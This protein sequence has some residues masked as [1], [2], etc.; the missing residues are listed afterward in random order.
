MTHFRRY[1][2]E[3]RFAL[4]LFAVLVVITV[5]LT[6]S[7]FSPANFGTTLGLMT[8]LILAA[9]AVTPVF[10]AGREGIDLSVGP[11]IGFVSVIMV[12][13]LILD[14]GLTSPL[15][16]IPAGLLVGILI[17]ATNGVLA[18]YLRVQPIVA[19]L[20]TYLI[21]T[22]LATW[23]LPAPKG[24]VPEWMSQ[25]SESYSILPLIA[26]ALIWLL[27]KR[28]PLYS[29][30]LTIGGEDRAAYAAGVNVD[31]IRFLAYVIGGLFAAFAAISLTGLLGSADAQVGPN[32]TLLAIAAVALGGV[33]LAG[34]K[35]TMLGAAIGSIDIFLLQNLITH[36]NVSSFV[37]QIVYGSILV[38]A[39]SLNSD[40]LT[41]RLRLGSEKRHA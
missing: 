38:I 32:Y 5:I 10:L 22:G 30:I 8:P 28:L 40:V 26:V 34:G 41:R 1:F 7:R 35:G 13:V 4:L 23:I 14:L 15:I 24:P 18:V 31:F 39:V 27:I 33:S 16:V 37:L 2:S 12:K 25:F 6:P 20:G 29:L 17:G 19:T 9:C 21:L 36:F 11:L 3:A